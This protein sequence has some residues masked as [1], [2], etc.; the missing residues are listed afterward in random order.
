MFAVRACTVCF[1]SSGAPEISL[2]VKPPFVLSSKPAQVPGDEQSRRKRVGPERAAVDVTPFFCH[3]CRCSMASVAQKS[4][5]MLLGLLM[6]LVLVISIS[7]GILIAFG[8]SSRP[9]VLGLPLFLVAA[10]AAVYTV[11]RWAIGLG[12]LF[13]TAA[14]NGL[15]IF[16][17]GHALNQPSNP[18]PRLRGFLILLLGILAARAGSRV[19][20]STGDLSTAVRVACLGVLTCAVAFITC[21]AIAAVK[22]WEIPTLI[23]FVVCLAVLWAGTNSRD[24]KR[25]TG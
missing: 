18:V 1:S 7:S 5:A 25:R 14:L 22:H 10:A 2:T 8:Y 15:I 24:P 20:A 9:R 6:F 11:N 4:R 13:G 17:S 19:S 12:V 3:Y 16:A 21:S 23:A